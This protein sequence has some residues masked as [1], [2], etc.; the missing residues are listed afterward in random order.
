MAISARHQNS[1]LLYLAGL[2]APELRAWYGAAP[3]G[4][5][6]WLYGVLVSAVQILVFVLAIYQDRLALRQVVLLCFA[7]YTVWIL[8]S[9]WRCAAHAAPPWGVLAR[10][11]T[12][13]WAGN[14][15]MVVLFLQIDLLIGYAMLLA[16]A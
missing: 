2:F 5:V 7:V 13:A 15:A 4:R 1:P 10:W 9:V 14:A 11:L 6:F 16:P 8:V 12:V 3:L